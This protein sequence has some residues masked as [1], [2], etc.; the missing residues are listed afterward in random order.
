MLRIS[1]SCNTGEGV[2]LF[3]QPR[4]CSIE[5]LGELEMDEEELIEGGLYAII[6]YSYGT[7]G[8]RDAMPYWAC[9]ITGIL[10]IR[11]I[12]GTLV[13]VIGGRKQNE[14]KQDEE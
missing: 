13:Q 12:I 14:P 4:N 8:I 7:Q 11:I 6:H 3:T 1:V 9:I 2:S 10:I 5:G